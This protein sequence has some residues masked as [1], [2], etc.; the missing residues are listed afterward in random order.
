[1]C[2]GVHILSALE[3]DYVEFGAGQTVLETIK[4]LNIGD[5]VSFA[6]LSGNIIHTATVFYII[7]KSIAISLHQIELLS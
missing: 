1:V 2:S 4:L 5:I 7:D 6:E 3:D